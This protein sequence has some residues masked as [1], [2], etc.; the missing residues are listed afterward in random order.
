MGFAGGE[1]QYCVGVESFLAWQQY[2]TQQAC[3]EP[4]V[5]AVEFLPRSKQATQLQL[6]KIIMTFMHCMLWFYL[7]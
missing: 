7:S 3:S 6:Q 2:D 1:Q 4:S 5:K